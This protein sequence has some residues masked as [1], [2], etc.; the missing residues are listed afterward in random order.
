MQLNVTSKLPTNDEMERLTTQF[1]SSVN[2]LDLSVSWETHYQY[3]FVL[4]RNLE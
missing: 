2:K 3:D 4:L 1:E